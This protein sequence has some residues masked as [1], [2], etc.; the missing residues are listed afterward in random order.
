VL[1]MKGRI[2]RRWAADSI[3]I[4]REPVVEHFA[5]SRRSSS[6]GPVKNQTGLGL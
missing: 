6:G 2:D 5:E 1:N 4:A 3:R